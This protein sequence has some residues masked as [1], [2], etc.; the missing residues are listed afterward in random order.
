MS[1]QADDLSRTTVALFFTRWITHLCAP[2]F[3]FTAGLSAFLSL[4]RGRTKSELSRFLW[5]RDPALLLLAGLERVKLAIT[6][7]LIAFGR[8]PLFYFILHLYL[9][10]L[11]AIPLALFRY[12]QAAF[13]FTPAPSMGGAANVYPADYSYRLGVLYI[14]WIAVVVLLYPL[15]LWFSRLKERRRDWWL[16]YF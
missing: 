8:V 7:P 4:R 12:G 5:T 11:L 3:M 10:H 9:I 1:F 16:S 15:C 6:N 14:L 2:V 13:L